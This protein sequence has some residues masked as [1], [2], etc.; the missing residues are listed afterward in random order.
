MNGEFKNIDEYFK[1]LSSRTL[2]FIIE[3]RKQVINKVLEKD[4]YINEPER[5]FYTIIQKTTS[6]FEAANIF[7]RNY[8][9]SRDFQ[10]PLSII[11]RAI[12]SDIIIAESVIILSKNNDERIELIKK[13]YFD[14]IEN[15]IKTI[16]STEYK[17]RGWNNE[18]KEKEILEIKNNFSKYYDENGNAKLKSLNTNI[19]PLVKR[20]FSSSNN[21]HSLK[22]IKIAYELYSTFSKL[23]H[24]GELSFFL[25]H[26]VY[27]DSKLRKYF[28]EIF[29]AIRVIITALNNYAKVWDDFDIDFELMNN[30]ESQIINL[31]PYMNK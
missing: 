18:E 14:H 1:E 29:N 9:S 4:R 2:L 8:E 17:V 24:F 21:K 27:D 10:I 19:N 31:D 12:L 23:E 13:V 25:I 22:L 20:I 28:N 6:S 5:F 30:L 15:V 3:Y 16:S 7:I 26:R 11:L